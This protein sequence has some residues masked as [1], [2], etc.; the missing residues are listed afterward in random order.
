M[1]E[2]RNVSVA[3]TSV[4][5]TNG[6]VPNRILRAL[7]QAEYERIRVHLELFTLTFGEILHE[8]GDSMHSLY[9]PNHGVISMLTVLENGDVVEVA[10]IGNEGMA[11]L[12]AF[13]GLEVSESRLL[14]QVPGNAM[15][16]KV[17]ALQE[18]VAENPGF[19]AG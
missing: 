15:R 10:T 14:V 9:F 13:L 17:D 16:I 5:E 6:H 18:L 1:A 12:S 8:P 2:H 19:R 3:M 4:P 7:P 11:D